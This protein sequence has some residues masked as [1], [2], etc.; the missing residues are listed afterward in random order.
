MLRIKFLLQI[1][2][3]YCSWIV[4]NCSELHNAFLI[5]LA[6]DPIDPDRSILIF[7]KISKKIKMDWSRSIG[8]VA[9]TTF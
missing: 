4:L 5:A 9:N 8:S 2:E 1:F 6:N 3:S 7:S